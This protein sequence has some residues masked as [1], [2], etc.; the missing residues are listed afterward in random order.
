MRTTSLFIRMSN[1]L[2]AIL[3]LYSMNLGLGCLFFLAVSGMEIAGVAEVTSHGES[4]HFN[5]IESV[6]LQ[7]SWGHSSDVLAHI[8]IL[9]LLGPPI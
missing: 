6:Y 5:S 1:V 3:F 8:G 2:R 4:L 7:L 9:A